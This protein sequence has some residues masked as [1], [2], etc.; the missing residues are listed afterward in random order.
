[1]L[2]EI[3]F[4]TEIAQTSNKLNVNFLILIH[5][6]ETIHRHCAT[7]IEEESLITKL[8]TSERAETSNRDTDG[9]ENVEQCVHITDNSEQSDLG[10]TACRTVGGKRDSR[11]FPR[12]V[13]TTI[14]AITAD[15][16]QRCDPQLLS[17]DGPSRKQN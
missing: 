4:I 10:H 14:T 16:R 6:A 12:P 9:D 8:T 1:M 7:N 13:V 2:I 17:N 3:I 15:S 11:R 5:F